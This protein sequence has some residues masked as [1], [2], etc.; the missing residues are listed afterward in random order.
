ME[1]KRALGRSVPIRDECLQD[2]HSG[3]PGEYDIG[4]RNSSR[5]VCLSVTGHR[6]TECYSLG[7]AC[8]PLHHAARMF[9]NLR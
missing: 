3:I 7:A 6:V 8:L 1:P 2:L 4:E 9:R 5:D